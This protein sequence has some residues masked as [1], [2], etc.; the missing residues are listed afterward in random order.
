MRR[1]QKHILSFLGVF[2]LVSCSLQPAPPVRPANCPNRATTLQYG[3]NAFLL[4]SDTARILKLITTARFGWVRQQIHWHDIEGE[5]RH[6]VWEP[7]DQLVNQ[8]RANNL[9][10]LLSVVRTPPWVDPHGG[11]PIQ[12]D[13]RSEF[14][15]FMKTLAERYRGRVAAYQIWNE[16]NLAVENGGVP[17]TPSAYLA[18]LEAAYPAV[19][20]GDPCALVISAA[21]AANPGSDSARATD[22]LAFLEALYQLGNGTFIRSADIVAVHPGGGPH[23]PNAIW[24][25]QEPWRSAE[26][27]RHIERVRAAMLRVQDPRSVWIT[28]VGWNVA[29]AAGA[30]IPVSEQ[31][32]AYYL[33]GALDRIRNRYSWVSATFV[34][35][36]NFAVGSTPSDEKS[37]FGILRSDYAPR[38]SYLALQDYLNRS[39]RTDRQ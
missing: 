10:I 27:F 16:P 9:H 14:A 18:M 2:L 13:Q 39:R 17:A 28:E 33:V 34:W 12:H 35:N 36:L 5:Y 23:S 6:Y 21:L 32:Q 24:P 30:P 20:A 8:A 4:G 38:Q 15:F 29:A 26:Y 1:H 11:I 25:A 7:L 22:D 31:E 3:V 19:K 37:G